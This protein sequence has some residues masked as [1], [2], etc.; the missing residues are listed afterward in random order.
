LG[1]TFISGEEHSETEAIHG[2]QEESVETVLDIK[3]GESRWA[4]L[5][6]GVA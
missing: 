4:V 2:S 1:F 3:L 5:R 6:V